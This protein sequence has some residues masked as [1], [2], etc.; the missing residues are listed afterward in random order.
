MS[1]E[2]DHRADLVPWNVDGARAA[3]DLGVDY[4]VCQGVEAGGHVQSSTP[5]HDLL[6]R[7][8]EEAHQTPVLAAGGIGHG[9]K[10]REVLFAGA[11]GAVLGTRFVATQE[12]LAHPEYKDAIVRAQAKGHCLDGVLSGWVAWCDAP[13]AAKPT[14]ARWEAAGCP[15]VGKRPGEG[16][17]VATRTD[18]T[19]IL[20]Y[21][22][23]SPDRDLQGTIEDLAIHA[24]Q[25]VEDVK[26]L[27]PAQDLTRRLWAECLAAS[28]A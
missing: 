23:G 11:A 6:P 7:I 8:L 18:G 25:G 4:L 9:S 20:R 3:L 26:D 24:G 16:D 13:S 27:P 21:Y 12:S 10:I 19:R 15:A 1:R 17:V 2:R 22:L 14:L 5:L 28:P